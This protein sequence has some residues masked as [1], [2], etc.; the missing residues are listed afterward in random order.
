[1]IILY[2]A[3]VPNTHCTASPPSRS[4]ERTSEKYSAE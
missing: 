3:S 4:A 2:S 1:M